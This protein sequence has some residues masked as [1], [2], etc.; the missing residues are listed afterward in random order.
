MVD[1]GAIVKRCP[2]DPSW[3]LLR[4]AFRRLPDRPARP[5]HRIQAGNKPRSVAPTRSAAPE[6]PVWRHSRSPPVT[7][8]DLNLA[9]AALAA[10]LLRHV[11]HEG[12]RFSSQ[13][14]R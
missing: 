7:G 14:S 12:N 11:A 13:T 4:A 8:I 3:P 9:S 1:D 6:P 10:A 2:A 5:P